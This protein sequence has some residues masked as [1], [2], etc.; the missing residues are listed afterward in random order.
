MQNYATNEPVYALATSYSPSALAVIRASGDGVLSLFA[1]FFKG[2][3][4]SAM[5]NQAVHGY[6]VD[7]NGKKVD[8]VVVIRYDKGHGYTSEEAFEIMSHGSLAVIR[9]I[10][11]VL[12]SAGIRKALK[13]EFT[14][15]A[16]MHGRMDLTEAEAVEEIVKART[17]KASSSALDRL[18][19][20]IRKEAES[21][22]NQLVEILA[23]LEV[24]LD[25]GEDE[26]IE[27][28]IFPRENVSRIIRRL[29]MIRD[30]YSASRLYS[31]GASVVL[32][33]STNAGKSSLFNAL[34]KENR[35]IVSSIA[36]TTRDYIEAQ[37]DIEGIPV[38]LFD[39]AG[40]RNSFD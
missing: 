29:E 33:G 4:L 10:S 8:E 13:G 16:F 24:H 5:T 22:K 15:R 28:W 21:I 12:E 3:L 39:T 38:R 40:L 25:Y 23:S 1:P 30:T 37:A 19:G 2:K 6:I 20:S 35:A 18:C 11:S 14:Y 26:I 36:G 9:A 34:L 7:K 31:E 17:E 27:P 32:A